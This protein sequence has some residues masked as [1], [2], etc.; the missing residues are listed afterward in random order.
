MSA[1]KLKNEVTTMINS[2]SE[3]Q[4]MYVLQFMR[5]I[6]QQGEALDGR[7]KQNKKSFKFKNKTPVT[8]EKLES[9]AIVSGNADNAQNYVNKMRADRAF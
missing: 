5:F 8:M 6:N 1:T 7:Q 9:F 2:M 3:S 4:L